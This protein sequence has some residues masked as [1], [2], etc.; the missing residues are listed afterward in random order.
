TLTPG[1]TSLPVNVPI[2]GD[3]KIET[4]ENFMLTVGGLTAN[5]R[6]VTL[7]GGGGTTSG[8]G[9]ILNDDALPGITCPGNFDQNTDPGVCNANVTLTLPTLSSVCGSSTLE[10]RH[11]PVDAGNV[12]TGAFSAWIPSAN[13][14]Q[15][16]AKGRY[17][18]EWRITDGS[19]S[20]TSNL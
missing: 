9:T 17:E 5:G 11:R 8:T 6:N 18:V 2:V 13:N 20:S 12:P 14:T 1:Q 3:C 7:S 16:F 10:F 15:N 4:D 19:G